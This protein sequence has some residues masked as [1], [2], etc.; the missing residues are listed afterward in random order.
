MSFTSQKSKD[1][2]IGQRL[3]EAEKA[4]T[5]EVN[6]YILFCA[7]M[8]FKLSIHHMSYNNLHTGF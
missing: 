1:V 4:E 6:I 3:I 7:C 5:G 8:T 2:Q